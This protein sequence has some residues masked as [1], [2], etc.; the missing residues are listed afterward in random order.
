MS[1]VSC[2]CCVVL[3]VWLFVRRDSPCGGEVSPRWQ[4]GESEARDVA[5]RQR[6]GYEVD[7]ERVYVDEVAAVV[8]AVFGALLVL[9]CGEGLAEHYENNDD[10]DGDGDR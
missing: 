5:F 4:T 9:G 10:G 8:V 2:A 6:N 7:F 3:R 1:T